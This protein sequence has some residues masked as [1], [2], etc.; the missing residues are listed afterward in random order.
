[1]KATNKKPVKRKR[2]APKKNEVKPEITKAPEVLTIN[3]GAVDA[4][5]TVMEC[6]RTKTP[7]NITGSVSAVYHLKRRIRRSA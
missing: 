4:Y 6:I 2:T 5:K 1:M 3:A 7:H